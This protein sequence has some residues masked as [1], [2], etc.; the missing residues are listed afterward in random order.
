M[1]AITAFL[2][3]AT[4][5]IWLYVGLPSRIPFAKH[6]AEKHV[7]GAEHTPEDESVTLMYDGEYTIACLDRFSPED[8]AARDRLSL[9]I[10]TLNTAIIAF[11]SWRGYLQ[12]CS[13]R[14]SYEPTTLLKWW[15]AYKAEQAQLHDAVRQKG[16][17]KKGG[18]TPTVV[19]ADTYIAYNSAD[20]DST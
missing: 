13:A 19:G 17:Q 16:K 14:T 11:L 2:L 1:Y 18:A 7:D 9:L 8:N 10:A 12:Y 4:L 15:R 6:A 3:S 5:L 20:D